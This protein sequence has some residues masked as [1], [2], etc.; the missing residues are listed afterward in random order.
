[1]N[2]KDLNH[3]FDDLMQDVYR[4]PDIKRFLSENQTQ[5]SPDAVEKSASKLFEYYAEKNKIAKHEMSQVPGY[6]PVLVLSNHLIDI[7]YQPTKELIQE[8]EERRRSHLVR[9]ISM[10]KMIQDASFKDFNQNENRIAALGLAVKFTN[11]Y[12]Q[13]PEKFHKGVYIYGSFGVG[14]TYLL[15]AIANRLASKNLP[16]TMIH[17]PS[18]AVEMKRSI[19]GNTFGA[20]V[21]SLKRAPL[22]MIDDIGADASSTWIRDDV[23]GVILEY[24]MQEEL[25]TCFT[26]NFSMQQLQDGYL[27]ISTQG[28]EEPIKAQRIM[29]RIE[30]LSTEVEILD[31]NWRKELS[32]PDE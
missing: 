21:D 24:R 2:K 12:I 25:P 19:Q 23:L 3:R 20:K 17:F 1:M 13:S 27:T 7:G 14:K 32:N 26:S 29:E 16:S 22:L 15:G 30:Y 5:L 4:D 18:F 9:S 8:R 10:P 11:L 28:D 6:Q 31:T